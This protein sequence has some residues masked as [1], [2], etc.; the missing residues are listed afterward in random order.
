MPMRRLV[1][2]LVLATGLA[3]PAFAQDKPIELIVFPGG[4]N[5]PIWAAQDK[6]L[7][8][9]SKV[10]VKITPT[11]NSVF[12]LTNLIEGKFDLAMTAIDKGNSS[13]PNASI[14]AYRPVRPHTH[15][16][17]GVVNMAARN[18]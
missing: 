12:Q 10:A 8:A 11:P 14:G 13:A 9:A 15:P 6:G 1:A 18:T 16:K 7:F 3:L 4:F 17:S 5:W 2:A